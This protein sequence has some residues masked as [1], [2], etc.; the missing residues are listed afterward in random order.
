MYRVYTVVIFYLLQVSTTYAIAPGMLLDRIEKKWQE[1]ETFQAEFVQKN[2]YPTENYET[3]YRGTLF[4]ARPSKMRINYYKINSASFSETLEKLDTVL[5]LDTSDFNTDATPDDVLYSDGAYLW[6]W[7][8]RNNEVTKYFLTDANLPKI[9]V[10]L[11]GA[12]GFD[13]NEFQKKNYIK[14]PIP[15]LDYKGTLSYIM[16]VLPKGEDK[17]ERESYSLWFE[18]ERFVPLK[19]QVESVQ[20]QSTVHI[21]NPEINKSIPPEAFPIR[22]PKD[23]RL[24][25]LTDF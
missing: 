16:N 15:E 5:N 11:I 23:T 22:V 25:D 12:Q 14:A 7:K 20:L 6:L 10:L 8:P 24:N 21:F 9:L 3:L 18:K 1:V 17:R 19:A 13:H 2:Y 4:L